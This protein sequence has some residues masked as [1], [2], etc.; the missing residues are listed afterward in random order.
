MTFVFRFLSFQLCSFCF[1]CCVKAVAKVFRNIF[2]TM[3][4]PRILYFAS[5]LAASY[6][7]VQP[8]PSTSDPTITPAPAV[9]IELLRKQNGN[10]FMGWIEYD[11]EWTTR[12]C[13]IGGTL[14]QSGDYWRCCATTIASCNVPVGCISG[15]LIYSFST[16]TVDRGTYAWYVCALY[17]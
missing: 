6:A 5:L 17:D 12:Q 8:T 1:L 3:R 10:R 11:G 16:G 7:N 4:L 2:A 14:Y 9:P 13:D 15:S